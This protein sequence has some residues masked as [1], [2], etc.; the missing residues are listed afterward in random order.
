MCGAEDM[1]PNARRRHWINRPWPASHAMRG[2]D[3]VLNPPRVPYEN[4]KKS[5]NNERLAQIM[6]APLHNPLP[7]NMQINE[8]A[9]GVQRPSRTRRRVP[10]LLRPRRLVV[11]VQPT[12]RG[13]EHQLLIITD[14]VGGEVELMTIGGLAVSVGVRI[15]QRPGGRER[16]R[17]SGLGKPQLLTGEAGVLPLAC[18]AVDGDG[19][20][21]SVWAPPRPRERGG[22]RKFA[23][24]P[25]LGRIPNFELLCTPRVWAGRGRTLRTSRDYSRYQYSWCISAGA[26]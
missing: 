19:K 21:A 6:A 24:K 3:L 22:K 9:S 12:K 4:P 14:I 16:V 2:C 23:C 13:Y 7:H 5:E 10:A 18:P 20:K 26:V 25:Q 8:D 11:S 1:V 15:S 17:E